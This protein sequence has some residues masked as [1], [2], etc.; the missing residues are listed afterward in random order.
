MTSAPFLRT[1]QRKAGYHISL[2]WD[3]TGKTNNRVWK[4]YDKDGKH[5]AEYEWSI[6]IADLQHK[7]D[8][9]IES[10][11]SGVTYG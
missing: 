4:L 2:G 10:D 5:K 11:K 7:V 3:S 6:T 1:D 9:I 8:Q